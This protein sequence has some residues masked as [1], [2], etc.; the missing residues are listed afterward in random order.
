MYKNK[1]ELLLLR[2]MVITSVITVVFHGVYSSLIS[3]LI[4]KN[5]TNIEGFQMLSIVTK[6]TGLIYLFLFFICTV[7]LNLQFKKYIRN[8]KYS[9]YFFQIYTVVTFFT[10]THLYNISFQFYD[11]YKYFFYLL[12]IAYGF[13]TL[14]SMIFYIIVKSENIKNERGENE[15]NY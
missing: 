1:W 9:L 12:I 3:F 5:H 7:F 4:M 13:L 8:K 6:M 10:A 14:I 11:L 2:V 15:Q